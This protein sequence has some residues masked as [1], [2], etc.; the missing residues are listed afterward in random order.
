MV[1][2]LSHPLFTPVNR[3]GCGIVFKAM[4]IL[5]LGDIV[6]RPGRNFLTQYLSTFLNKFP[7]DFVVANGENAAGGAGIT[8]KTA[9]E[10]NKAG[11]QAIT[12]GDHVWDQKNFNN[13]IDGLDYVCRPANLPANNPGR[14]R[15]IIE[16]NGLKVG[17]FTVLGRTFMGPKVDCPFATSDRI[18]N[19]LKDSSDI[20]LCE[21][22]AETTSEKE[23]MGWHLDGR[24]ALIYG[25][26]TH[27][28]TAD[29]RILRG[30]SAY[31]S[32]LGMTGP[33]ES[34]LGR[35][36]DACLGRFKDGMP[37]KC[38]VAE[39]DVG[40]QGCIIEI[41]QDTGLA[42]S[43]QLIDWRESDISSER[44]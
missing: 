17:L 31:Q 6:G 37:R 35:D 13:E 15:L 41:N 42:N 43:H 12:L 32:D 38:P 36:I 25:T 3:I 18:V 27:V 44:K 26:H 14:D 28:P 2:V 29:G 22:H 4:K 7:V 39:G 21:I 10:I 24:V 11:V 16:V 40:M 34:V 8:A 30:G 1:I 5:L 33:R 20:V 23:S 19:E 9:A